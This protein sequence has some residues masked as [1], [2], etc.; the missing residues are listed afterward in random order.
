M[1]CCNTQILKQLWMELSMGVR[2]NAVGDGGCLHGEHG[3][4]L[5]SKSVSAEPRRDVQSI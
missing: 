4:L 2:R 1:G 3:D 5:R